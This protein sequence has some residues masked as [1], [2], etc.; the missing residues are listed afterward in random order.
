MTIRKLIAPL[1]A[2][3]CALPV[4]PGLRLAAVM[5]GA[6]TLGVISP[7]AQAAGLPL[8]I[9]ATVDYTHNTLTIDGQNFGTVS[10]VTL[11]SLTFATQGGA[12]STQIIAN[13]P[14]GKAP[15]SFTPGT[16][17]L[18]LT[19]KN[20]LPLI[21]TVDI[22]ANGAPGPAGPAGAPGS[23]GVAGAT[24][25][26]GPAGPQGVPGP[27]GPPGATGPTGATGAQG[28]QGAAGPQ[29]LQGATGAA[30]AVG[31]QGVAG[32]NGTNGTGAPVCAASDSVVSYQGTLVCQ[33]TLPHYVDNLDGTVTDNQTGLMWE[34]KTGTVSAAYCPGNSPTNVHD[35]NNCY[36][37][38]D[39]AI[40]TIFGPSGKLYSV[41]LQ[42]LNGLN[43]SVGAAC[44]AGHCDWRIPEIG[45]LR[46]ILL[47]PYPCAT[48]PCIDPTYFTPTQA[49]D[50][51]SSS[52]SAGS[53]SFA[54]G[55][56]FDIGLVDVGLKGN[57]G[58][59]RAV[60]GGR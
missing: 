51:W 55:V 26:A 45:E 23:P 42:L 17:F 25:P 34:Q 8:I 47:A 46:S 30:G 22:G 40:D 18:T 28:L 16:Y 52:S 2:I 13:F 5:A 4:S 6:I 36:T 20:Q 21:F 3:I 54:W 1:G 29:G 15:S 37:W 44:F 60:R 38:N 10:A 33:S 56:G 48:S 59:A 58:Y 32:T 27:M 53:P 31:P 9:S 43:S 7:P 50:Y 11:D 57:G 41:F 39:P 35:V 24:G 19:F 49:S 12:S 14:S